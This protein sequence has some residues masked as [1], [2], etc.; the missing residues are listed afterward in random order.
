LENIGQALGKTGQK[1]GFPLN[2]RKKDEEDYARAPLLG[3]LD[4]VFLRRGKTNAAWDA[5]DFGGG[6]APLVL[7]AKAGQLG[8]VMGSIKEKGDYIVNVSGKAR[9]LDTIAIEVKG[10]RISVRG[11][12]KSSLKP[13]KKEAAMFCPQSRCANYVC[14]LCGQNAYPSREPKKPR[15]PFKKAC[16]PRAFFA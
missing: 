15:A 3:R 12:G 4:S 11:G 2:L 14:V 10:V 7:N 1:P 9:G 6:A 16:Q 8:V 5:A 13:G